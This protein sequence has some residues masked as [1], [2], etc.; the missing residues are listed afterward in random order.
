ML[1]MLLLM[2]RCR[3]ATADDVMGDGATHHDNGKKR[4]TEAMLVAMQ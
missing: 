4:H 3:D 1:Q 2:T